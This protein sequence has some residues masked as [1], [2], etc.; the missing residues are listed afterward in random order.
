MAII[1]AI[2]IILGLL[3]L[4]FIYELL[5]TANWD[6]FLGTFTIPILMT[7][8]GIYIGIKIGDLLGGGVIVGC[9]LGLIYY[10]GHRGKR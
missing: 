6:V 8:L 5:R 1:Y 4:F 3:V 2:L 9:I 10:W 7:I